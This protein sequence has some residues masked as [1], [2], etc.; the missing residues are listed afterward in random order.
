MKFCPTCQNEYEENIKFCPKDGTPLVD[1]AFPHFSSEA[2]DPE[3]TVI[4]HNRPETSQIVIPLKEV[5][6]KAQTAFNEAPQKK[7]ISLVS[8]VVLT[9]FLTLA[10]LSLG[11]F[12]GYLFFSSRADQAMNANVNVFNAN[13]SLANT[14][15]GLNYNANTNLAFN[16]NVFN[17]NISNTNTKPSPA[18]TPTKTPSPEPTVSPTTVQQQSNVNVTPTPASSPSPTETKPS[19]TP[20]GIVEVGRLNSRAI[21]LVRPEYPQNARQ[22]GAS[23]IVV[24]RVLIDEE[25]KV[26]MAKAISGHM[27]LRSSA[28]DA[29]KQSKFAPVIVDGK[30]TK[31]S[32]VV[33]YNFVM[34]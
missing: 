22:M 29:A 20:P 2:F 28:E 19:P 30:P 8:V 3:E 10:L 33:L 5:S 6:E 4:R 27:L 12:A 17:S 18:Q 7:E 26:I 31:A 1:K 25:G 15:S 13:A 14:N 32:G 34:Q 24:I 16:S 9:I 11:F 23:G 21:E